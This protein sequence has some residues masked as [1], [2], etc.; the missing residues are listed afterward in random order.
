MQTRRD[1][2][3]R[4]AALS[5][6]VAAKPFFVMG[7]GSPRTFKVGMIGSGRRARAAFENLTE[8]AKSLGVQVKLV[9][10]HDFYLAGR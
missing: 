5:T 1:F 6:I 2:I 9:A 7:Q 4:A 3:K 10:T 8:A